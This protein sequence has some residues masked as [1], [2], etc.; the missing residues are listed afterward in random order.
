MSGETVRLVKVEQVE[1][2]RLRGNKSR[3]CPA[4]QNLPEQL[5]ATNRQAQEELRRQLAPLEQRAQ[6]L[7]QQAPTLKSSLAQP[8]RQ[9]AERLQQQRQAFQAAV[10]ATQVRQQ[11]LSAQQ[12]ARLQNASRESFE[13]QRQEYLRVTAQQRQEYQQLIRQQEQQFEQLRHQERQA[14]QQEQQALQQQLQQL[15]TDVNQERQRK[16]KLAQDLLADVEAIAAQIEQA[17][18]HQRFAPGRLAELRQ[19]LELARANW[20]AGI[21]EAA[22][23]SAQQTYLALSQLRLDLERQEQAWL[24]RY[25]GALAAVRA[26]LAEAQ[27]HRE[28]EIRVGEGSEA[29]TFSLAVDHWSDGRLSQYEQ[30][31]RQLEARLVAGQAT[32]SAEQVQALSQEIAAVQPQLAEIVEQAQQAILASQLRAEIADRVVEALGSLGYSLADPQ[33]DAVYEGG[34]QRAAYVVKVQNMAGDEVVTVISPQTEFGANSISINAFSPSI[35][36]EAAAQQN[37][38]AIFEFLEAEG[39]KGDGPLVCNQ[40]ARGEYR[41]LQAVQQRPTAQ[42]SSSQAS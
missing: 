30:Q 1:L 22:I 35:V 27:A 9:A 34:D 38:K 12:T 19:G 5:Q 31:L 16:A 3:V 7:Q 23:A 20:Q 24:L 17:Y 41:N 40:Q 25:N 26:L 4:Q 10:Q 6:R 18:P 42:P 15:A 8:E 14:R 37:A 29:E 33:A 2:R 11:Q 32:L 36:D 13:Q 21:S 39:V 28:C